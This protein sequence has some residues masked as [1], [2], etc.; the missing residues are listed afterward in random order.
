MGTRVDVQKWEFPYC[1]R[2]CGAA[3]LWLAFNEDGVKHGVKHGVREAK[4]GCLPYC[5]MFNSAFLS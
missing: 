2:N 5:V 1:G 3:S 4:Q